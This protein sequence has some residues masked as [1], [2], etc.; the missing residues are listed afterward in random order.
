MQITKTSQKYS[1]RELGYRMPAE[2]EAHE[3]CWVAWPCRPDTF[4]VTMDAVTRDYVA[5]AHAIRRFENVT[6]IVPP[7]SMSDARNHLGEDIDL[8]ELPIDDSWTRDTGPCFLVNAE[9]ALAGADF[10]FNAWGKNFEEHHQDSQLARRMLDQLA[11]ARFTTQLIAEG[12][13]LTVD[14]EGTL[15]TTESC[16]LNENRNPGW[17]KHEVEAELMAML[18]VEKVIWLP[19][20]VEETETNGHV[21]GIAAFVAPGKVL[22]EY[23]ADPDAE[24]ADI[25]NANL[26]ALEGETDAKGRKLE[27][28]LIDEANVV[29]CDRAV[30]CRS[31]VNIYIANGAVI[32]PWYNLPEDEVAREILQ[33]AFPGREIV[34]V[35]ISNLAGGGGG[36]HCITQQQPKV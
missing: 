34:P 12:G 33:D 7:G 27:T 26:A 8:V 25:M 15:I 2:W 11:A 20:N 6:M 32:M 4:S 16:L 36:I 23:R 9:G 1:A 22:V 30:F 14:G 21:D 35:E 10:G 18:G 28:V 31:Y 29:D 13:G 3:R 24:D 5:V 19:G 17:T